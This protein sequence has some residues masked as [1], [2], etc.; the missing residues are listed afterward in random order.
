M[1]CE[2]ENETGK[3]HDHQVC[4]SNTLPTEHRDNAPNRPTLIIATPKFAPQLIKFRDMPI[5]VSLTD[6]QEMPKG[7]DLLFQKCS[8]I[9][10][11]Q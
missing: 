6:T 3:I 9:N 10:T 8:S 7:N 5:Q 4:A 2:Y 1:I 11:S